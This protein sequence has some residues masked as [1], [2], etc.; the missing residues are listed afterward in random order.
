MGGNKCETQLS[1]FQLTVTGLLEDLFNVMRI[2]A[3]HVVS[4]GRLI[5][6]SMKGMLHKSV[7]RDKL[8]L[9]L[10]TKRPNTIH[11]LLLGVCGKVLQ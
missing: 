7:F 2:K 6:M 11:F 5:Q 4:G 9:H 8:A 3:A 10:F 1:L